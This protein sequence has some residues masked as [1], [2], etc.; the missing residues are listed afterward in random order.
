MILIA[1][2]FYEI[3]ICNHYQSTGFKFNAQRHT[4]IVSADTINIRG[5]IV[6]TDSTE[7]SNIS[8]KIKSPS[9]TYVGTDLLWGYTDS[10]GNFSINGVNFTAMLTFNALNQQ[11]TFINQGSR[12]ITIIL[13]PKIFQTNPNIDLPTVK[14]KRIQNRKTTKFK[15]VVDDNYYCVFS[16]DRNPEY[17]GGFTAF[18]KDVNTKLIIRKQQ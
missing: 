1:S 7:M 6:S 11:H 5:R 18:Y 13:S 10:V 4:E 12:F 3:S 17:S 8:I 16:I 14:T 9:R 2:C 15:L